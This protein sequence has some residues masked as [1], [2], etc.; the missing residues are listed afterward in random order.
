MDRFRQKS[1]KE[2]PLKYVE[3]DQSPLFITDVKAIK[4]NLKIKE[5]LRTVKM[6]SS[7]RIKAPKGSK[8]MQNKDFNDNEDIF[9]GEQS[10][11]VPINTEPP[12]AT[13]PDVIVTNTNG[14]EINEE[15]S[16]EASEAKP[17]EEVPSDKTDESDG[18]STVDVN[19]NNGSI[20]TQIH[21]SV[22]VPEA[23]SDFVLIN[24]DENKQNIQ[25]ISDV[26]IMLPPL[27]ESSHVK[28]RDRKLSLDQ[29][30]L[31]RRG[32]LSQSELDLNSIGKSPLERKSS[33]FRKKMDSFLRNTTEIF[34]RQSISRSQSIQRRGSMSVSLQSL[35]EN[36]AYNGDYGAPLHN[37]Q[38]ELQRSVSSLQL[39][40]TAARAGSSRSTSQGE[41]PMDPL[42]EGDSLAGSRPALAGSQPLPD[43]SPSIQSLNESY[44]S[45]A[46]LNRAI[47]MSSGLDSAT[48]QNRR[49]SRSNRVTWLAS[50]GVT[51]YFRRLTQDEKSKEL[52]PG[53]SY[54]D[55]STIPENNLETKTDSKGRRL[56]YQ[57]AV[58]GEDPRYHESAIKKK[59]PSDNS[60]SIPNLVAILADFELNGIPELEG[61]TLTEIPDEALEYLRWAETPSNLEEFIAY[62]IALCP[63]LPPEE[64]ARQAVI[65]E[66][67]HTEAVYIH[68]LLTIVRLFIATAHALQER[69]RLLDIDTAKL[70]TNIPDILNASLCFW[71]NSLYPMIA[72]ANESKCPFNTEIMA[73]GF[74]HFRE[75]FLP[76]E[77][78]VKS[79]KSALDYLRS[80]TNNS[81]FMYYLSWCYRRL[82]CSSPFSFRLQLADIMVK[83]MQRLTK[84]SLL[85]QRMLSHTLTEPESSSLKAMEAC[86]RS[87]VTDI[88][89]SI[90]QREEL[91]MMDWLCSSI[92]NYEIDFRDEEMDRC[93]RVFAQ[94]NLK[95]PMVN[96][97]PNHSRSLVHQGDLRYKDNIKEM[98]V[99]V[100][101]LTDM[102]LI[103]KKQSKGNNQQYKLVRPKFFIERLIVYPR[104][105]P[106]NIKEIGSLVCV[107]LDDVGSSCMAFT[108]SETTS[109]DSNA[110]NCLKYWEH[111]L[112]EAR[113]TYELA[114][115]FYKNPNRDLSEMDAAP[116][117]TS[118]ESG[119]TDGM[120][121]A[122]R[123]GDKPTPD[124][125]SI[126]REARE[127]V[128]A[129]LHRRY[130]PAEAETTVSTQTE[131][132]DAEGN[133]TPGRS[134]SRNQIQRTSTGGSS[135][136]SSFQQSSAASND[137]SEPGPSRQEYEAG[138]SVEHI[139]PPLH[140]DDAGT[141]ITVNVVSDSETTL[142]PAPR[143]V[144]SQGVPVMV[145]QGSG[146]AATIA[147]AA[148]MPVT[149]AMAAAAAKAAAAPAVVVKTS[150][151]PAPAAEP[152]TSGKAVAP[153]AATAPPPSPSTS[154]Q[155]PLVV[156]Q[157]STTTKGSQLGRP[158]FPGRNMLR[159]LPQASMMALVHSLP[160]LT[161]DPAA[162]AAAAA[163]AA[164]PPRPPQ[165]SG[166]QTASD[167]LYQSHQEQLSRNRLAAQQHQQQQQQH[168]LSPDQRGTSYPPPSPSRASLKRGLA[169][170]YSFKNPPLL[171]M[172]H[173]NS[174][175]AEAVPST[176]QGSKVESGESPGTSMEKADKKSKTVNTSS[177]FS[178]GSWQ[179]KSEG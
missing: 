76:Y 84:Y 152:S 31:S 21:E 146:T 176:S 143:P 135:R 162:A 104:S 86:A 67:I 52:N 44:L 138:S 39:S 111:K 106:R 157:H 148:V 11:E 9:G 58:S 37:H 5:I 75:M 166:P 23:L 109:K 114:M 12:S 19:E 40:P 53:Y 93:Y 77:K 137:D 10:T 101:L 122:S 172:G 177:F 127:R 14:E 7:M 120:P 103:C 51:N 34:K 108:L 94:L 69:G 46:M 123:P 154:P 88:N 36:A 97:A 134:S 13:N 78:Y 160:D 8:V 96:C 126:D 164:T 70:F 99:R 112:R 2:K 156:L 27:G 30:M 110:Q 165:S 54:P 179:S 136:L 59:L 50:E 145:R 22:S 80:L 81:D 64:E 174:Q 60:E 41:L 125:A 43:I 121:S 42:S 65:K 117:T 144:S 16:E 163:A 33:F 115:W 57:R 107:V 129:M 92:E 74:L 95:A 113:I 118:S 56:S 24:D 48:G 45:E 83:P 1:K 131:S 98:E 105:S 142:V 49:K 66:L 18:E 128:A 68:H 4:E 47:S 35:T 161:V 150:G 55:F 130:V 168:Y 73:P 61:F 71:E 79:Q 82:A 119:S 153:A 20:N 147:A 141:S 28:A 29:T 91:Q 140:P 173:V 100:F 3:K 6:N 63:D 116:D 124:E 90:R 87:Y 175:Q 25:D 149:A 170:S 62:R 15:T 158:V 139:I 72:V 102:L 169:F 26:K 133:T 32:G 159:V 171:K 151:P 17:E 89:R 38:E 167:R 155:P 178:P 132:S 85:L